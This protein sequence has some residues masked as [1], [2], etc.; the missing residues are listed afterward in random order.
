MM[1]LAAQAPIPVNALIRPRAGDFTYSP[2][3]VATMVHDIR[4]AREAGIAGVVIGALTRDGALDCAALGRL[5]AA[6]DGLSLTL[7]RA[8]DL[9]A[10]RDAALE[11]AITLGFSRILTS[12]GATNAP[13]GL[14]EIARLIAC[15]G[16]RIRI[17]PGGGITAANV[18]R[19]RAAGA[20]ELH[21][22]CSRPSNPDARLVGFG[23]SGPGDRQ[24]DEQAV[25]ALKAAIVL[26][27]DR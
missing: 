4:M 16:P 13:G 1:Q 19:F 3:E 22:S 2:A 25:R 7:S 8:F 14:T 18:D 6:A 12:G 17:L 24:I 11:T 20:T 15:A 27:D 26:V 21:A 9:V 5:V 23:F 10:D